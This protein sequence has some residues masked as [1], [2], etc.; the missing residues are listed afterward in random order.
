MLKVVCGPTFSSSD[1][2]QNR[3]IKKLLP[4]L[5]AKQNKGSASESGHLLFKS[6]VPT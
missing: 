6:W 4:T 5:Y 1:H 3:E 2:M